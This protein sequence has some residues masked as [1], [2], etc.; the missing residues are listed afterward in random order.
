MRDLDDTD[1]QIL[2]LLLED[3]RRPYAD[4]AERVDLSPPAVSDRVERLQELG[5]IERFTVDIDRSTLRD[6]VQVLVTLRPTPAAVSA[7][8]A[9]LAGLDGVEHLFETADGRIVA[10]MAAPDGEVRNYLA[11]ALDFDVVEDLSVDLL[12]DS[13]WTPA[14]GD[15]TIGIDCVECSNTVTGEGVLAEVGGEQRAFCCESCE[16]AFRQRYEEL[17]QGA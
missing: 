2:R 16:A 6:G 15:A 11:G 10:S 1:R 8:R 13:E 17:E 14:L 9:E 7:V 3:A 4:I 5:V 12:S